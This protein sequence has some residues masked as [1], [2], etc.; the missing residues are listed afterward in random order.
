MSTPGVTAQQLM[1]AAPE[2]ARHAALAARMLDGRE[3]DEIVAW[4]AATFGARLGFTTGLGFGG[5]V[6]LDLLRRHMPVVEVFFIDTG[7]HFDETL[8]LLHRLEAWGEGPGGGRVRFTMVRSHRSDEEVVRLAGS[9][10]WLANPDLCCRLRKVEPMERVTPTRDAWLSALRRDQGGSRAAVDVVRIDARGVLKIHPLARWTADRCWQH[11]RTHG[12]PYNPLHDC[13]YRSVG[14]V[15]CTVPVG[16]GEQER[17]GRWAGTG[18][19]ECGL[20]LG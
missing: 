11:I 7:N 2:R 4:A 1:P 6:L 15:H 19:T 12:L 8:E 16:T 5:V 9:P 3:P 17:A 14:C 10:P 18:K 13:G 20:H